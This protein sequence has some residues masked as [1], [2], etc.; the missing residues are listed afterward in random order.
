MSTVPLLNIG[1]LF[2]KSWAAVKD[3][4]AV[5][6]ALS[7]VLAISYGAISQIPLLGMFSGLLT[8]G[9]LI[10]LLKLKDRQEIG[11]PDF[12][13][14]VTSLNRFLQFFAM[15]MLIGIMIVPLILIPVVFITGAIVSKNNIFI[16]IS[17]ISIFVFLPMTIYLSVASSMAST[18][19]TTRKQD[20]VVAIKTSFALVKGNW[21]SVFLLFAAILFLN[22]AGFLCLVFGLLFTIPISTF[23]FYFAM[24]ELEVKLPNTGA[25]TVGEVIEVKDPN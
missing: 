6:A 2:D 25:A 12:F 8:P 19:F 15:N 5:I 1:S 16:G 3:N 23:M 14:T 20:A 9:Y 21:W 10:C 11:I 18:Y 24:V 22:L 17:S 4:M 13:W 7:L